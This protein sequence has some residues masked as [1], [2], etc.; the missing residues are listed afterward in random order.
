MRCLSAVF[1]L[2]ASYAISAPAPVSWAKAQ[3]DLIKAVKEGRSGQAELSALKKAW[4]ETR[5]KISKLKSQAKEAQADGNIIKSMDF[6]RQVLRL[7][8]ED[9]DAKAFFISNSSQVAHMCEKIWDRAQKAS[10]EGRPEESKRIFEAGLT[11]CRDED[12]AIHQRLLEIRRVVE[13]KRKQ[14]EKLKVAQ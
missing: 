11:I 9:P 5:K 8:S 13:L 7:D 14:E 3:E 12:G 4:A 1:L 2:A 10:D 6:Y